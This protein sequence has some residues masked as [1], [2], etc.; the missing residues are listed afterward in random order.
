MIWK[1][2]HLKRGRDIALLVMKYGGPRLLDRVGL[3]SMLGVEPPPPEE[4]R[5]EAEDLARDLERMGPTF[6]KLGQTLSTRADLLPMPYLKAL[7]RLQDDVEPFPFA[8]VERIVQREL[9]Q[10]ISRLFGHFESEPLASASLGQVHRAS[11]RDGRLVAVKVQRPEIHGLILDDLD[12]LE[13]LASSLEK[14]S[15]VA[16]RYRAG[17]VVAEFRKTLLNELDYRR[18]ARNLS[19]LGDSMRRRFERLVVPRPIQ[20][21]VTDKVLTMEYVDGTPVDRASPLALLEIDGEGLAEEMFRAYLVQI[22]VDGLYHADPHPGNI[23]LTRDGRLG[24][25]DLG[26]VGNVGPK[27]R[28]QLLKLLIALAE[29]DGSEAADHALVLSRESHGEVDEAAFRQAS[30][31]LAARYH[32]LSLEEI[33]VG[34][35]LMEMSRMAADHG[36][37]LPAELSVLGKTLMNL[38]TL[39][40]KLAPG[41]DPNEWVRRHATGLVVEMVS[42][43]VTPGRLYTRA[44]D[45]SGFL[46]DLPGQVNRLL[47]SLVENRFS[48]KVDAFDEDEFLVHM[49]KIANRITAGLVLAAL[50]IGAALLMPVPT[51]FTLF[52]YPGLA[53]LC[54]LAAAAGGFYLVWTVLWSDRNL[55]QNQPER[56]TPA[57]ASRRRR[58]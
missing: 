5:P 46:D 39:G 13:S 50:I 9:G 55:H 12:S 16:R 6:V 14:H 45:A 31:E 4:S 29:G 7:S 20:G 48:V 25:L 34:A 57:T 53:I 2:R 51:T 18:E 43:Q 33:Q 32:G 1:A 47:D 10:R 28:E 24:L 26:M 38:D 41:S 17:A 19:Q 22:L 49:Q 35:Q 44:L 27:L 37:I 11:L 42:N 36:L 52:G 23:L 15:E 54:F 21:Y 58:V 30:S 3:A 56:T 8:D 40:R